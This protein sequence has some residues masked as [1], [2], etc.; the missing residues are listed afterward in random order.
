MTEGMQV[1][2]ECGNGTYANVTTSVECKSCPAGFSCPSPL[3]TPV[4]CIAGE[5]SLGRSTQC[6][7]CPRGHR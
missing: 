5:Y 7:V 3:Q 1:Q 2:I 6:L 4:E